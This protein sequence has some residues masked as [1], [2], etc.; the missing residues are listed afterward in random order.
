MTYNGG[1]GGSLCVYSSEE[2]S[3]ALGV[4]GQQES[5][6]SQ[7]QNWRANTE[8]IASLEGKEL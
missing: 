8:F 4:V 3:L 2:M 6:P 7:M 1:C 5:Y